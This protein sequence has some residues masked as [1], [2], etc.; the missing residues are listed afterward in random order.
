MKLYHGSDADQ[1]YTQLLSGLDTNVS[2][3]KEN[4]I[5]LLG[6]WLTDS[7]DAAQDYAQG[8][9]TYTCDVTINNILNLTT[10]AG[11]RTAEYWLRN[12]EYINIDDDSMDLASY[13]VRGFD[14]LIELADILAVFPQA[15][16]NLI[17]SKAIDHEYDTVIIEDANRGEKAKSYV[18]LNPDN[19]TIMEVE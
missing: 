19:I 9:Y 2:H 7:K 10:L 12:N 14:G 17:I 1:E 8:M 15:L 6:I 11:C 18:I 16:Q 13:I 4:N 3:E 5:S